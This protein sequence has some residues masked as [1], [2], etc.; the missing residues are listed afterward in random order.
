MVWI[1]FAIGAGLAWLVVASI[2]SAPAG[3]RMDAREIRRREAGL[4]QQQ[5]EHDARC[6]QCRA[7]AGLGN[8]H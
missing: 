6:G 4:R 7:D 2:F 8:G 5:A 1:L 3:V